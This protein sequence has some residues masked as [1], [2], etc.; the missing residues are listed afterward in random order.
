MKAFAFYVSTA[1]LPSRS[2]KEVV[3]EVY[4]PDGRKAYVR[5]E[6]HDDCDDEAAL[7]RA[8]LRPGEQ[9]MNTHEL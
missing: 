5:V 3:N 4:L 6:Q 7:D 9:L 2:A 1:K 8:V